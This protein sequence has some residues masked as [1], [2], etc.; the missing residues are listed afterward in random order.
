MQVLDKLGFDS[1]VDGDFQR[2]MAAAA[3][4]DKFQRGMHV[5]MDGAKKVAERIESESKTQDLSLYREAEEKKLY[6][7]EL[8][9]EWDPSPRNYLGDIVTPLDAFDRVLYALKAPV[10]GHVTV[11]QFLSGPAAILSPAL[12]LRWVQEGMN[13]GFGDMGIYA[14]VRPVSGLTVTPL[15]LEGPENQEVARA[16]GTTSEG[17]RLGASGKSGL[18]RTVVSY[19]DK[20]VKLGVYG[21]VLDFG[22]EVVKYASMDELKLIFWFIGMQI[23]YDDIGNVFEVIDA[24]D[25]T[26]GAPPS[27]LQISGGGGAG[28]LVWADVTQAIAQMCNGAPFKISHWIGEAASLVDLLNFAQFTGPNQRDTTLAQLLGQGPGPINTPI[29]VFLV[30]PN[31]PADADHIG[32]FDRRFAIAKA[33]ESMLTI[34]MDKI[35]SMRWEEAAISGVWGFWKWA[36]DA[37]GMIDYSA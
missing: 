6:P 3:A 34:E 33:E 8:M 31:P 24:G 19:R 21:R 26:S 30:S 27:R 5:D 10:S 12:I 20:D 22:Y 11:D 15:Y 35:I 16:P 14:A 7:W 9:E 1:M 29:G 18:P 28:T 32:F 17:K 36:L 23:A 4:Q 2:L 25:G 13:M 37:S